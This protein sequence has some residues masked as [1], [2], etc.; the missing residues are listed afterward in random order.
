MSIY[1]WIG[2]TVILVIL[3]FGPLRAAL[4]RHAR[5]KVVVESKYQPKPLIFWETEDGFRAY[6]LTEFE[7]ARRAGNILKI[8]SN[9]TAQFVLQAV[10]ARD[11]PEVRDVTSTYTI[12]GQQRLVDAAW[13]TLDQISRRDGAC[14]LPK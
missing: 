5:I 11:L 13:L 8:L 14:F 4:M 10:P 1:G 3:L 6:M 7:R 2:S 12:T 9:G